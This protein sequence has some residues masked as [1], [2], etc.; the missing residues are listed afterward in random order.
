MKSIRIHAHGGVEQLRIEDVEQPRPGP[1]Q[2]LV[3][4]KAAAL[5]HLDLWVR[6]GLPGL[7]LPLTLGSDGSGVVKEV[8]NEVTQFSVGDRVLAQPGYGCGSCQDCLGGRENYCPKY[9]IIGEHFDGVQTQ[10]AVLDEAKAIR[11]PSNISFEEG[12]AIPLVYTTAWEML[13][14]KCCVKPADSVLV[15]AASSGVGSAA[16]QIARAHGARVIATAGTTK[17]EKARALGADFVLDHYKQDVAKEVKKITQGRGVEIVV[18]HAGS[19]TWESSMR[20]LAKG[21]KLTLC[22]CTTGYQVSLDLR[23]LFIHQQSILGSTMGTRGDMF[24]I[25]QLVEAGRMKGVVDKVFPFTEV[26]KAHEYL[27]SGQQFGKVIL[28]FAS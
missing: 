27:E 6:K 7:R 28:S 14:N 18:D 21:G 3:E 8:G 10:F 9:G 20:S 12:A 22:G 13:V 4:V 5:N 19:A 23:F 25:L 15:V 16:V 2:I 11:Q 24:R 1:R 26:A 17:L